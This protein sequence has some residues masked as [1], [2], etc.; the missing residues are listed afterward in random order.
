[1]SNSTNQGAVRSTFEESVPMS[2]YQ[3][4]VFV[5]NF[6]SVTEIVEPLTGVNFTTTIHASKE[7]IGKVRFASELVGQLMEYFIDY[8]DVEYPLSKLGKLKEKF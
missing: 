6:D 8:F 1:M 2:P 5:S 7:D 3:L 4:A